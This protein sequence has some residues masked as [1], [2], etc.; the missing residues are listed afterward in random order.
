MRKI[1]LL[2][3]TG[4]VLASCQGSPVKNPSFFDNPVCP[5]PCW[6]NITPGV[7]TKEDALNIMSEIDFVDQPVVDPHYPNVG[8]DD[9]IQFTAYKSKNN[10]VAGWLYI[11]E[12]HVV[13]IA[14]NSNFGSIQHAIRLFG[15]PQNILLIPGSFMDQVTLL[16]AQKGV[17]FGYGLTGNQTLDSSQIKPDTE[18]TQLIFFNP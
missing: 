14:F 9:E 13:V 18:F 2:I 15:I 3:L 4:F 8:F 5:P 6:Q 17:A 12:D 11:L 1:N 7:T 16:N 10:Y